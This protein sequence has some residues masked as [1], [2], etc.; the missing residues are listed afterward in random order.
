[1]AFKNL[2]ENFK[3]EAEIHILDGYK[4]VEFENGILTMMKNKPI[5]LGMIIINIITLRWLVYMTLPNILVSDL[6]RIRYYLYI[7]E[8]EGKIF[9]STK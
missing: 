6:F 3:K 8:V 7:Q 1:M 9:I 2:P 4:I 5:R